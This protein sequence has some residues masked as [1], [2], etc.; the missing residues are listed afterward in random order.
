MEVRKV[1][2]EKKPAK[3]EPQFIHQNK[4]SVYNFVEKV[5][6]LLKKQP[7]PREKLDTSKRITL[8]ETSSNSTKNNFPQ[9]LLQNVND[10]PIGSAALDVWQ[11]FT[12]GDGF[13]DPETGDVKVNKNQTLN[14]FNN[15]HARDITSMEGVAIHIS[16]G[17]NGL[18]KGY[19]H[20][21]FESTRLG[22]L[23]DDGLVNR[24]MFNPYYGIE[25]DFDERFTKWFYTFEADPELVIKE[26]GAHKLAFNSTENR[27]ITIPYPGQVFWFSIE[28]PL[29]RVYPQPFYFSA[30]NWFRIDKEI[31]SFHERNIK[32][33]FLL[34]VIINMFGNPDTP[35]GEPD[36]DGNQPSTIGQD[37]DEQMRTFAKGDG[38]AL[39]NWFQSA[40]G[41]A[42]IDAFPTNS[43]HDLFIALQ[44]L[45]ADQISIGTKT[46][47]ILLS[48]AESGKLGD[49]QEI[50]NA[51]RVMQGRTKRFREILKRI[52]TKIFKNS[53]KFAEG[54]DFT[55]RNINPIN[56]LPQ[57]VIDELSTKEKRDYIKENFNV[58]LEPEQITADTPSQVG[59]SPEQLA[60]QAQLKGS[61]GGVQ[62]IL[63]I[64]QGVAS[65]LAS[66]DSALEVLQL[67]YGFTL[68]EA[69]RLLGPIQEGDAEAPDEAI[70]IL[71]KTLKKYEDKE[72]RTA[73]NVLNKRILKYGS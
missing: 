48:I 15:L 39:V 18:P 14:D 5:T 7:V 43:H 2:K 46:P 55:I 62:G 31:Q 44:N 40:E 1:D 73:M 59:I 29:A 37:F 52:Y 30:I 34:S 50:L 71:N 26:M 69:N 65:G 60:A 4:F 35:S 10:S 8:W 53:D 38:S 66:R 16:Y 58:D 11:E 28:K 23:N 61:V 21:P 20:M 63:A 13:V 64:Q 67:I 51:I 45:T 9:I 12:E 25:Q 3:G 47:R 41:K 49:T 32:N 17:V 33:N 27:E 19:K 42:T 68:D 36:K 24:I 57:W 72:S 54:T 56:I 6:N 70:N 22:E